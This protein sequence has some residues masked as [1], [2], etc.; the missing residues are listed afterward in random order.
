MRKDH[1]KNKEVMKLDD[2][3]TRY[4][5]KIGEL[6]VE[7]NKLGRNNSKYGKPSFT[8]TSS[9]IIKSNQ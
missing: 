8:N 1:E 2:V 5:K 7:L 3:V 4:V 6:E 9:V